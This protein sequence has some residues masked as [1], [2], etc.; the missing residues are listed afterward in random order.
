METVL[1]QFTHAHSFTLY[2]SE[3]CVNSRPILVLPFTYRPAKQSF[4]LSLSCPALIY[5][6]YL[7]RSLQPNCIVYATD[8]AGAS[9]N[10]ISR[11]QKFRPQQ[12]LKTNQCSQT[13]TRNVQT[14]DGCR[15]Y[16]CNRFNIFR[17]LPI[18]QRDGV[19]TTL[20]DCIHRF[21]V[22]IPAAERL[23]W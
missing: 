20:Y 19:V 12:H 11:D 4:P 1:N 22:R 6:T 7:G 21:W 8:R 2:F 16:Y 23:S 13:E 17:L 10:T 14:R 15:H 3:V 9:L 18:A 5:L